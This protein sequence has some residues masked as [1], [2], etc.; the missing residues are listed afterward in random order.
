MIMMQFQGHPNPNQIDPIQ[1]CSSESFSNMK[2]EEKKDDQPFSSAMSSKVDQVSTICITYRPNIHDITNTVDDKIQD[3]GEWTS[4]A[5]NSYLG[6][7]CPRAKQTC[8]T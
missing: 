4:A 7:H 1:V 5:Q 8:L 3:D 6:S 2:K